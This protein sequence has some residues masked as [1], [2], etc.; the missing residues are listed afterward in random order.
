MVHKKDSHSVN[1]NFQKIKKLHSL[2][3]MKIS[4]KKNVFENN[5]TK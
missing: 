5:I 1:D 3:L 4:F 2:R